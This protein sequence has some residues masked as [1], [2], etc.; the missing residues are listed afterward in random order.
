MANR[1]ESSEDEHNCRALALSLMHN[2]EIDDGEPG[3]AIYSEN[4]DDED[5]FWDLQDSP[6]ELVL[7][8][9]NMSTVED[10]GIGEIDNS[11]TR[12]ESKGNSLG[13]DAQSDVISSYSKPKA[14]LRD[15]SVQAFILPQL[16]TES[17]SNY[18]MATSTKSRINPEYL[19]QLRSLPNP[20]REFSQNSSGLLPHQTSIVEPIYANDTGDGPNK[21]QKR[22]TEIKIS[23]GHPA[24]SVS[25]LF[26]ANSS[27][28]GSIRK[29]LQRWFSSP[30]P[31]TIRVNDQLLVNG[32]LTM[33][34]LNLFFA[35]TSP[36]LL[37]THPPQKSFD[38][39]LF[40]RYRASSDVSVAVSESYDP[41]SLQR[42]RSTI[43]TDD[44]WSADHVGSSFR[45][46]DLW[47]YYNAPYGVEIPLVL[48]GVTT[49]VYFVPFLSALQLF[50]W[51]SASDSEQLAPTVTVGVA[52]TAGGGSSSQH[53][54]SS[55]TGEPLARKL[56]FEYF[57]SAQPA[58]RIPLDVKVADLAPECPAILDAT[59]EELHPDSWYAISW[60]PILC[61]TH[62]ANFIRG[63]LLTYHRL[64]ALKV[65]HSPAHTND[66]NS[67][68]DI[69][70][71]RAEE[72]F[73]VPL[74]GYVPYK[75]VHQTWYPHDKHDKRVLVAPLYLMRNVLHLLGRLDT[76]HPDFEHCS[77][78]FKQHNQ[79]LETCL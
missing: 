31:F 24:T 29:R 79:V 38:P 71:Q 8:S 68:D 12:R 56:L 47:S 48:E 20:Q 36:S 28:S 46:A 16:R 72:S 23:S 40:P 61:H 52:A 39:E 57:E 18:A 30:P 76:K 45:L 3:S 2:L 15:V 54:A 22:R 55:S 11:G 19:P 69:N 17:D 50:V 51:A 65:A 35:H 7:S 37:A 14:E 13:S 41:H 75:T 67:G 34:N 60:Y 4:L 66:P 32:H 27:K 63:S 78:M 26:A 74:I 64:T 1:V 9:N 10:S 42:I 6:T 70:S 62:T 49:P 5:R 44:N 59:P 21:L 58:H 33:T 25:K 77:D 43:A 73:T 53:P